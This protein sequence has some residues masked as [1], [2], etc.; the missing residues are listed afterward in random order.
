MKWK[1]ILFAPDQDDD[2]DDD[3]DDNLDSLD[4]SLSLPHRHP[5]LGESDGPTSS[6]LSSSTTFS[7]KSSRLQVSGELPRR[8]SPDGREFREGELNSMIEVSSSKDLFTGEQ[9]RLLTA[10]HYFQLEPTG[11]NSI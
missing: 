5:V 1:G 3:D 6:N 7:K 10:Q 2:D 8:Q 4:G 11:I 9:V